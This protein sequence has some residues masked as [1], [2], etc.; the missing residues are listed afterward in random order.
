MNKIY[1][2]RRFERFWHWTQA[3][4]IIFLAI[5]GFEVHG[6]FHILGFEKA[7]LFHRTA[8][9]A[10]IVLI[11]FAIFWH[12]TIGEW[13]QY[14]PTIK[15][16]KEQIRF[17]AYGMF[18]GEKHP[19]EKTALQK[20]NPL[21]RIIYLAFKIFMIPIVIIS[22]LLYMFYKTIDANELVV[23]SKIDLESIALWHTF[24]AFLLVA[25]LVV[26]VYMTTTGHTFTSNVKAMITGYEDI[27]TGT[28]ENTAI[29]KKK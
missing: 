7:V 13:R 26:H 20:L 14:I 10:L 24:G 8:S 9:I 5:S 18:I 6:S 25:F 21:Q 17:Y 22:G 16:L 19:T 12:F 27:E 28:E 29:E 11:I 1:I 15:K 3:A 2:Y 23:V 4:L